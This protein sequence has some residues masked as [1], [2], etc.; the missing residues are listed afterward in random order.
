MEAILLTGGASRRMGE[1]KSLLLVEREP[2]AH[3]IA[4]LISDVGVPVTV[5]GRAPVPGCR[6]LNDEEDFQGPLSALSRHRATKDFVLVCSCDLPGFSP[7][8]IEIL[9]EQIED[10]DAAV[11]L[12]GSRLQPLCALY[13]SGA[14]LQSKLAVDGGEK[15]IMPWLNGLRVREVTL[16]DE[17]WAT[18]VNTAEEWA[19]W[20][21]RIFDAKKVP[22]KGR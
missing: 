19:R 22:R 10:F 18:N 5:L 11:P 14:I 20:Q 7:K 1:D 12:V 17:I 2:L 16:E 13:T 4:R 15:R 9:S 8:L 6:F 3:R 21:G